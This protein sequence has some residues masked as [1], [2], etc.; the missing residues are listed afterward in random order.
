M[1]FK[2]GGYQHPDG[3]VDLVRMDVRH[4]LSPRGKR[5]SIVYTMFLK[6]EF[7]T[8][9]GQSAVNDRIGE[10]IAAYDV[11]FVTSAGL[12]MDDGTPTHHYLTSSDPACI[13]GVRVV[14]RSWPEGGPDEFVNGRTFSAT[15]EAEYLDV[16]SQLLAWEESV[17]I[18]GTCGPR[19]EVVELETGPPILQLVNERTAQRIIQTGQALG[20]SVHVL[21]PGPLFPS[22]EHVDRRREKWGSGTNRGQAATHYPTAWTYVMSTAI[23]Q[24]PIPQ[25]R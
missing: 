3:E 8:T 23:P 19:V 11:P 9:G 17:E 2:V 14:Q 12:Y 16:E 25:T 7:C 5:M 22:L 6:G 20:F 4:R 1:Y 21:P 24:S 10:L 13:S 18:H 15:L